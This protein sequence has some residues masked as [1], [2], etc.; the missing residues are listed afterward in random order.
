MNDRNAASDGE[1]VIRLGAVIF[2]LMNSGMPMTLALL[3]GW[4]LLDARGRRR[5]TGNCRH[6]SAARLFAQSQSG[7]PSVEVLAPGPPAVCELIAQLVVLVD[8]LT[9]RVVGKSARAQVTSVGDLEDDSSVR[10]GPDIGDG[11]E[12]DPASRVLAAIDTNSRLHK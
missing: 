10:L 3:R 1:L 9:L 5:V 7:R 2:V 12:A 11:L 8:R 4:A 6:R